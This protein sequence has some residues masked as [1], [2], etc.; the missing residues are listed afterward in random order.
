MRLDDVQNIHDLQAYLSEIA[1]KHTRAKGSDRVSLVGQASISAITLSF[2]GK[3]FT[4]QLK[5]GESVTDLQQKVL[6]LLLHRLEIERARV[7][8]QTGAVKEVSQA[9]IN[10]LEASASGVSV[11]DAVA[12]LHAFARDDELHKLSTPSL[13]KIDPVEAFQDKLRSCKTH[14]GSVN[15]EEME[16]LHGAFEELSSVDQQKFEPV[17]KELAGWHSWYSEF[18]KICD[19]MPDIYG[20]A[21]GVM[22]GQEKPNPGLVADSAIG[23]TKLFTHYKS[24]KGPFDEAANELLKLTLFQLVDNT[25]D[26]CAQTVASIT[27]E[28]DE[29]LQWDEATA[30]PYIHG[31]RSELEAQASALKMSLE[32]LETVVPEKMRE[33]S[34]I[35]S[36]FKSF[37]DDTPT[38]RTRQL[39]ELHQLVSR[40]LSEVEALYMRLPE[41]GEGEY[42]DYNTLPKLETISSSKKAHE[43]MQQ[44]EIRKQE[45]FHRELDRKE[46]GERTWTEAVVSVAFP[47]LGLTAKAGGFVT[48]QA[49]LS[50][51]AEE[52]AIVAQGSAIN[53]KIGLLWTILSHT[54]LLPRLTDPHLMEKAIKGHKE[55]EPILARYAGQESVDTVTIEKEVALLRVQ[56]SCRRDTKVWAYR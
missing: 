50:R 40:Q 36:W 17:L 9:H 26:F 37:L 2:G 14:L 16:R 5:R 19:A 10:L 52:R 12:M 29:L 34:G 55:L 51:L 27:A 13:E 4:A 46:R 6:D 18:A 42:A 30:R 47:L 32:A 44:R 20:H 28:V 38:A 53:E 25:R 21:I 7:K 33:A 45:E 23:I 1:K 22:R 49:S 3:Q 31:L 56:L 11:Q 41:Q 24:Y 43:A 48:E 15:A 54:D 8:E 39:N 35:S